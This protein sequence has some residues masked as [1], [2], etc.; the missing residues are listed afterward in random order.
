[1][2]HA[3]LVVLEREV[4]VP[5]GPAVA[6]VPSAA[7][8]LAPLAANAEGNPGQFLNV[9]A[10]TGTNGKTST[11]YMLA[12]IARAAG[13]I[14][15]MIGT[16]GHFVGDRSVP[17]AH[18]T[19][20][21]PLIQRLLAE[22]KVAGVG[23]VAMEAS[24]IGLAAHRCDAIPFRAAVFTNLSR[25]HLD[26]HG[27]MDAYAA[28][29]ARLFRELLA[30]PAVLNVDDPQWATMRP[31]TLPVTTYGL[32]HPAAI[33]ARVHSATV[34]GIQGVLIVKGREYPLVLPMVGLHNLQNALAAIGAALA[35][36]IQVEVCLTGLA[37]FGG[38]PGRLERVPNPRGVAV[39][40]D[41]AH[42]DD[43][44]ANVIA[45]LRPLT[46]GRLLT[47]FGCGGDRDA[48]KRPL[49]GAAASHSDF[50]IVTSDNPRSEDPEEIARGVVRGLT[51]PYEVV[52]S[53]FGAIVRAAELAAAGDVVLIAGKGHETYQDQAGTRTPFD[54]R[55]VAAEAFA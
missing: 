40:V 27:S 16:T 2:G 44:L 15:G 3:A 9:V 46:S 13:L 43:A 18:T 11:T 31:P 54:D 21:A 4:A 51:C 39:F 20:S 42:T 38:V 12:S 48:G 7:T 52:L 33:S 1:M 17:A 32:N 24:S 50:C 55:L 41:Y 6:L 35:L 45:A 36:N 19:P 26:V 53:R 14:P 8:A 37:Q 10:V 30:G 29:K 47:V 23:L 5:P 25:D 34:A 28:A 49:M 22:M